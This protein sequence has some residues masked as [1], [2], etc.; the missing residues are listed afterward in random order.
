MSNDR[1][2]IDARGD[3]TS[4]ALTPVRGV[5]V[6][7]SLDPREGGGLDF[8]RTAGEGEVSTRGQASRVISTLTKRVLPKGPA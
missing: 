6:S 1:D 7:T 4:D 3:T 2:S 8:A 5:E